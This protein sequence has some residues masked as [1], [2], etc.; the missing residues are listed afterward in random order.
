MDKKEGDSDD[1]GYRLKAS[2]YQPTRQIGQLKQTVVRQ[3]HRFTT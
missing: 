2:Y 3:L 1:K